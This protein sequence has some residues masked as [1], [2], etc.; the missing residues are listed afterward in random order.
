MA[1]MNA[2]RHLEVLEDAFIKVSFQE[3]SG[4]GADDPFYDDWVNQSS[5]RFSE[6]SVYAARTLRELHPGHSVVLFQDYETS[7]LGFSGALIQPVSASNL[8]TSL[9]FVPNPRHNGGPPGTLVDSVK[10]GA[11]RVAWNQY[12]FLLYILRYPQGLG[13]NTQ[14]YLVHDGPEEHSRALLMAAG[15]YKAQLHEEI[16]IFN[17]GFWQ[18]DHSLWVEVQKA[19]WDDVILKDKF[20][21]DLKKDV[22]GFFD[23]ED[24][25]KQLA[26]PWKRG[27]IMY[28]P[29]GNGKTIS[30]KTIMKDC[31][32]KG[33]APLYVKSFKS[34]MGEEG[35]MAAVFNK[36]REMA[37]CVVVLED[38][39]S[40]I[41]DQNRSFFLNQLDGLEGNDGLLV[42]GS[43]NH[44]ER[45]DPALSGRPSRF[46]RK[47]LFDDPD[48]EERA[49]YAKYWQQKLASNKSISFPDSLVDDVATWTPKFSFAY[50]KEAF[51]S[52]L[53]LLAGIEGDD[54]PSFAD[55]LHGQI[56][57][58]REQLDKE[59]EQ[60]DV[61]GAFT[62][63]SAT[64]AQPV[65]RFRRAQ[66]AK[67]VSS[68]VSLQGRIFDSSDGMSM[69]GQMP[70]V[71][72]MPR[73]G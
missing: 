41:N 35:S 50:L 42:I 49:L 57:S 56:R 63:S 23:S 53:V 14:H 17:Q 38:L 45:L 46:D 27:L 34:W 51:V 69:P 16:L 26:I 48:R 10:Y 3:D 65:P 54:K 1:G 28:G 31:D 12:D 6:P 13:I 73:M 18:K 58:L 21:H 11:F 43:T 5:A 32:A 71:R 22:F 8:I 44:F 40:L 70:S 61:P 9:F 24:L 66:L 39:D 72:A 60:L 4:I 2:T 30:M 33:F 59:P 19:N 29:P 47:Y 36:A 20:K 67:P 64:V 25:Y 55:V 52:T 15:G 37:P 7:I 68:R 62:T